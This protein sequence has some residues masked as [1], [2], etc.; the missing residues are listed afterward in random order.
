MLHRTG[1]TLSPL[2]QELAFAEDVVASGG[3]HSCALR[4]SGEVICSWAD[5]SLL[6][7]REGFFKLENYHTTK[8]LFEKLV[9][10]GVGSDFKVCLGKW[11]RR[12]KVSACLFVYC[13]APSLSAEISW[14]VA[15]K[16]ESADE[17]TIFLDRFRHTSAWKRRIHVHKYY[18]GLDVCAAT[19]GPEPPMAYSSALYSETMACRPMLLM[20]FPR[21]A[22]GF[23]KLRGWGANDQGQPPGRQQCEARSDVA[24]HR[25]WCG[26]R[27]PFSNAVRKCSKCLCCLCLDPRKQ[28]A[29]RQLV[30]K[31][32]S[33]IRVIVLPLVF[34]EGV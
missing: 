32:M 18:A 20:Q 26:W 28:D 3:W 31:I 23:R 22:S 19:T 11:P 2:C 6:K 17:V 24:L 1:L 5:D 13:A 10:L 21:L 4:P 9:S 12:S 27:C 34:V 33:Q 14:G 29:L 30:P 8:P 7:S 16:A 25:R 15:E